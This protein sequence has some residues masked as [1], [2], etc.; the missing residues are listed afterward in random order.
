MSELQLGPR[1][2]DSTRGRVVLLVRRGLDTVEQL[3]RELGVTDNAVRGHLSALERDGI[4]QQQGTRRGSGV[5]KPAAVFEINPDAAPLLS[6]AYAPVLTTLMEVLASQLPRDVRARVLHDVGERLGAAM[7]GEAR[8]PLSQRL[9]AAAGILGELGGD[10][11][12]EATEG[13]HRLRGAGCPLSAAVSRTPETCEA[14]AS[15]VGVIVGQPATV[16]CE[17]GANPQCRFAFPS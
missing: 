11:V 17:H 4:I 16:C 14:M 9:A 6:R 13:T 10:V 8:G 1:F 2:W 7:G 15:M 5:G 3:A 12:V